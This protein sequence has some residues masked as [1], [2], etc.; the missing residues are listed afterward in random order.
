MIDALLHGGIIFVVE[1]MAE[2]MLFQMASYQTLRK[3]IFEEILIIQFSTFNTFYGAEN[4]II[5]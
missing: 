4:S 3:N 2:W 1:V 5:H